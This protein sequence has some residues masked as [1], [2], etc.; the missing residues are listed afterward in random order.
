[1]V[2]NLAALIVSAPTRRH[3]LD[4]IGLSRKANPGRIVRA[5][6]CGLRRSRFRCCFF[7]SQDDSFFV[8]NPAIPSILK[9]LPTTSPCNGLIQPPVDPV[10]FSLLCSSRPSAGPCDRSIYKLRR[11]C[12]AAAIAAPRCSQER[13]VHD[14]N[15]SELVSSTRMSVE[16]TRAPVP[17]RGQVAMIEVRVTSFMRAR[18]FMGLLRR[19]HGTCGGRSIRRVG[20]IARRAAPTRRTFRCV[21]PPAREQKSA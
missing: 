18:A 2:L 20:A 21:L 6:S 13:G 8:R 11:S 15:S 12:W 10:S 5:S 9:V 1:M 16:D 17:Q 7:K 19:H 3:E 4:A 14:A